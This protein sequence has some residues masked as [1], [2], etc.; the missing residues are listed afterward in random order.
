LLHD[1][2]HIHEDLK[3]K[4]VVAVP[5]FFEFMSYICFYGGLNVGPAFE[6]K[7]YLAF[8]DGTLF[9]KA[10]F[11]ETPST[12]GATLRAFFWVLFCFP[13]LVISGSIPVSFL[14]TDAFV[15]R[16]LISKALYL[17][18]SVTF[19]RFKYY[20]AWYLI[21]LA[22]IS[23]GLGFE[24]LKSKDKH[25]DFSSLN[26]VE[27]LKVEMNTNIADMINSWNKGVNQ[28][29]KDCMSF[30]MFNSISC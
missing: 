3:S 13:F 2:K 10:G 9:A 8:Q 25:L 18:I 23:S 27:V 16:G 7:H 6:I 15:A 29:L 4:A 11:K 12:F 28:W 21:E 26:N 5:S 19:G 24:P 20:F 17:W 30:V 22:C 1:K 14:G